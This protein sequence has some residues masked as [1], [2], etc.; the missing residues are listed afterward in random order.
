MLRRIGIASLIWSC[1]TAAVV[2]GKGDDAT[3]EKWASANLTDYIQEVCGYLGCFNALVAPR[4][5]G[6]SAPAPAAVLELHLKPS[7]KVTGRV[8]FI[9][10]FIPFTELEIEKGSLAGT[11]LTFKTRTK[12]NGVTVESTWTAGL[13]NKE[14]IT[15]R[16]EMLNPVSVQSFVLERA[17]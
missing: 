14:R 13:K 2:I 7:Q 12:T 4:E 9:E 11:M 16:R 1:A 15:L 8:W 3:I 17:K 10:N 5:S 6:A